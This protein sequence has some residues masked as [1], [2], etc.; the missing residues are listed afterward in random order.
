VQMDL[1]SLFTLKL[2][3]IQKENLYYVYIFRTP[4]NVTIKTHHR[5]EPWFHY[6]CRRMVQV[7]YNKRRLINASFHDRLV[8]DGIATNITVLIV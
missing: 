4:A 6:D 7:L 3:Y 2:K 1:S 8:I 5:L